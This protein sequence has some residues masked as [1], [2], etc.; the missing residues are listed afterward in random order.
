[1]TITQ[2]QSIIDNNAEAAEAGDP[3]AQ[4]LVVNAMA[5]LDRLVGNE[6]DADARYEAMAAQ[7]EA[8]RDFWNEQEQVSDD[9]PEDIVPD[10][11]HHDQWGYDAC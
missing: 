10:W 5:Q 1:M 3:T 8:D 7:A 9:L 2:L 4:G 11:G 6:D